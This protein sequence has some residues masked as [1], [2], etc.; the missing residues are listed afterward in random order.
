MD[1]DLTPEQEA[2]RQAVR[3]FVDEV[4]APRAEEADRA[5]ALPMDV[6]R[7]M[8]ELGLFGIPFPEEYGGQ[9]GDHV[10]LAIAIEEIGR[11]DQSLGVT[12]SAAV[13]LG[14]GMI[15]R[16][17]D[18]E[19]KRRWLV[20]AARGDVLG[21]FAI[22]EPGAG[23]DTSAIAT[24][25]R[26]ED[27]E[28][29]IDGSKAFTTNSGT[30]I[31]GFMVVAAVTGDR[32]GEKE[33][34]TIVVPAGTPGLTVAPHYRKL[35]W[36][37]SD[38]HELSFQGCRVPED[39]LLGQRG[40]GLGQCLAALDGGR[41]GIAALSVGLSQACLDASVSYAGE[42]VAFGKPIA[43]HEAIRF[44]LADMKVAVEA[45]RLLT[46]RAAWLRDRGRPFTTEA[47]VAKLYASEIAVT[48]A[49]EAVQV[50]GG[51]GF[52]E[53]SAVARYY[54]DSKVLEIAEGTSEIQRMVIARE[55]GLPA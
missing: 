28:W 6:V 17:G 51:Y 4:V 13:G 46:Y 12:L 11:V 42:R 45:A 21:A 47:A 38:T 26:L 53:E 25:A 16:F 54:R 8:G 43:S 2:F 23:S 40:S 36:R 44:K 50:H 3:G 9:G 32:E 19:Q 1:F 22:S 7:Q 24:T 34:S 49:R 48:C 20:P 10:S 18:E 37:A 29:M 41:V 39:H 35:G 15:H 5:E 55:L 31:T 27:G 14:A 30:S 33:Y 52:I